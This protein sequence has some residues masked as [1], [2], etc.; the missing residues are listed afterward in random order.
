MT[1]FYTP[2]DKRYLEIMAQA[3]A[4]VRTITGISEVAMEEVQDMAEAERVWK[5]LQDAARGT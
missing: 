2:S 1:M 5:L 4:D 3:H